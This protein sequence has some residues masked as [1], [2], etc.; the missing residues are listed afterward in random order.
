MSGQYQPFVLADV[1][2]DDVGVVSQ[3]SGAEGADCSNEWTVLI[4]DG[5]AKRQAQLQ[6]WWSKCLLLQV[7]LQCDIRSTSYALYL[8]RKRWNMI[9]M[10]MI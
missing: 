6:L 2:Y 8:I 4:Q 9:R 5:Q 1:V 7:S 3:R 10:M